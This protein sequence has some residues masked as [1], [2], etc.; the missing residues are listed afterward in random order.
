MAAS[1]TSILTAIVMI[2]AINKKMNGIV[3]NDTF[4]EFAKILFS[5]LL[6]GVCV[7]FIKN[8]NFGHTIISLLISVIAGVLVYLGAMWILKSEVIAEGKNLVISKLKK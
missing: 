1:I 3:N 6:M 4:N 7:F 5:G 2:Y 8:I